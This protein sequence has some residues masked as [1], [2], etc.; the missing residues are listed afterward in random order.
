ML[1]WFFCC[2]FFFL[3][4]AKKPKQVRS[5]LTKRRKK[6]L[7]NIYSIITLGIQLCRC[8]TNGKNSSPESNVKKGTKRNLFAGLRVLLLAAWLCG[9]IVRGKCACSSIFFS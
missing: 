2:F 5:T 4:R 9:G 8:D 6:S 1:I 3:N 7:V